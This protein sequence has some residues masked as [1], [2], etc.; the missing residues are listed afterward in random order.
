MNNADKLPPMPLSHHQV[1]QYCFVNTHTFTY[2]KKL[3]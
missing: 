2:L 3:F 1:D